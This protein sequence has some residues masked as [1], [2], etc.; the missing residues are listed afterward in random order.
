MKS[1]KEFF[2][3]LFGRKTDPKEFAWDKQDYGKPSNAGDDFRKQ[4]EV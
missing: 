3:R 1:L 4:N 2:A